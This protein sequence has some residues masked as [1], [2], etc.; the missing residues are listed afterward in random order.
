MILQ[1]GLGLYASR[2]PQPFPSSDEPPRSGQSMRYQ[3]CRGGLEKNNLHQRQE[4]D[5]GPSKMTTLPIISSFSTSTNMVG[6]WTMD[7]NDETVC[8]CD[9]WCWPLIQNFRSNNVTRFGV[10]PK[11]L[12]FWAALTS[13]GAQIRFQMMLAQGSILLVYLS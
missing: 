8:Q 4:V 11:V 1:A 10:P 5:H 7:E 9:I 12:Q 13:L 3:Q 6:K 2:W